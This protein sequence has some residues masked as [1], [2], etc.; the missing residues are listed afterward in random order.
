M[1]DWMLATR[2]RAGIDRTVQDRSY[3]A[4]G[5]DSIRRPATGHVR[6]CTLGEGTGLRGRLRLSQDWNT[7]WRRTVHDFGRDR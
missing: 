5:T 3:S 1:L 7:G 4:A 2:R 6:A